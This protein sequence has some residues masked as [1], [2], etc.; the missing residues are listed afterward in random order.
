MPGIAPA[1]G[2]D[3]LSWW[4]AAQRSHALTLLRHA[5]LRI[6]F[7]IQLAYTCGVT[8]F[9][10]FYPLWLVEVAGYDARGIAW[11]T[12]ALCA[13]MALSSVVFGRSASSQPL[14][15]GAWFALLSALCILAVAL[16]N[17]PLGIAAVVLFGA[18][19]A[20]Y[21]AVM[22]VWASERYGHHGQGAVMGLWSTTFCVANIV[23][24]ALGA[25]LTL[26]DTRLILGVG[27][28]LSIWA[29]WRIAQW[30]TEGLTKAAAQQMQP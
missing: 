15:A 30:S 2:S 5:D 27:A 25:G 18:P 9:Y 7:V 22:P 19:N 6:L 14:R 20:I 23:M 24:A 17:A 21:N 12:A 4:Q 29:A 13:V 11:L 28:L 8:A 26:W 3:G 10:E 1:Q 16:G